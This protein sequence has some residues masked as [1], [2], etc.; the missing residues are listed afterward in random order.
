MMMDLAVIGAGPAGMAAAIAVAD[1]GFSVLV[2]DEQARAGGQIFRRPPQEW[3][4]RHGNYRPYSWAKDLIERFEDHPGITTAFRSTA[5]GVLRDPDD[6][7]P[8]RLALHTPEGGRLVAARRL[9][10]ATGAHDMPVAFPGWTLPGVMTA[11]AV[12]SLLK[13]QKLLMGRRLVLA[14]SHPILLI[15]AE[16]LLEARADIVEI[17][18]ARGLPNFAEMIGAV[19]ALP[20][21]VTLFA[22]AFRAM[23]KIIARGI[24]VTR[25]TIIDG[26]EGT[27]EVT[28]VR[29]AE[30][31]EGWMRTGK[32]R[33]V[34]ADL[35]VL[36]YGFNPSTELA[37]QAG[38]RMQWASDLG[39]WVVAHDQ[40][41]QT[42]VEGVFVA[43][44]PTG[45]A[46]A[47]RSW[48]EGQMAGLGIAASLGVAADPTQRRRAGRILARA[49]RFSRVI[50]TMFEPKR[51]ALARL[52]GA[53]D[54]IV[55]RCEL[56]RSGAL[57]AA[58]RKNPFLSTASAVKL[59]CRT[60]MGPCQGR[61]CEGTVAAR[62]ATTRG[63]TIPESGFFNANFPVKPVPLQSLCDL[64]RSQEEHITATTPA[65]YPAA[66]R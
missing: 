65:T 39:G 36:G 55:C 35:L 59:E 37:R 22:D 8:L 56:I 18:L 12:Q 6:H 45:I 28:G 17:A 4:Q 26:V 58:L 3:G 57:D 13:S 25:R 9:L 27:T 46:G 62:L 48:A 52:S 7:A 60:G 30:V 24:P 50:Q 29:L 41:F 53:E 15:L 42:S 21:H 38:C 5:F 14:G 2:V 61:Y 31:D 33:H 10:I 49:G 40:T 66:S 63:A 64:E 43:G 32:P 51:E 11:G 47:E 1:A 19:P 23:G 16:Q 44:E 54:V 34:A 20:G